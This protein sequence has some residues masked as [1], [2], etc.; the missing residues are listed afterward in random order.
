MLQR[1]RGA[2]SGQITA[3]DASTHAFPTLVVGE[4]WI[5]AA[6]VNAGTVTVSATDVGQTYA[7]GGIVVGTAWMWIGTLTN[8]EALSYTF[9]NVGDKLNW[10][11]IN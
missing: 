1:F 8:F 6:A 7:T 3:A 11:A 2:Q 9:S 10:L 5:Q 4:I